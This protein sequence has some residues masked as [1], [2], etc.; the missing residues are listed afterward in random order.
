MRL[1]FSKCFFSLLFVFLCN[2]WL[3]A[4][5]TVTGGAS[6]CANNDVQFELTPPPAPAG[7]DSVAWDF[8]DPTSGKANRSNALRPQHSYFN[9]GTYTVTAKVYRNGNPVPAQNFTTD[10]T[11]KASP[12]FFDLGADTIICKKG[13][14]IDLGPYLPQPAG[15]PSYDPEPPGLIY[16]WN[17]GQTTSKITVDSAGCYSVVVTDPVTGCSIT[18]KIIVKEYRKPRQE[19]GKWFFGQNAGIDFASGSAVATSGSVNTPEGSS[20]ISDV[21]GRLQFYTDGVNVYDRTG[22]LMPNGTGLNGS[23]NSTQS[24][25]IV[26][27]PDEKSC[28]TKYLIF[29]TAPAGTAGGLQYSTVDMTLNGGK[30]DVVQKNLP[31]AGTL[32][33]TEKLTAFTSPDKKTSWVIAHDFDSRQ[34]RVIAVTKEGIEPTATKTF[35]FPASTVQGPELAKGEGQMKISSSGNRIAVTIPGAAGQPNI[36]E[37]YEFVDTSGV[38]RNPVKID[39]GTAPPPVYGVEFS[40]DGSILYVSKKGTPA[41]NIASVLYQFDAVT[42]DSINIARSKFTVDSTTAETF[43][44][45][46]IAPDQQIYM[47]MQNKSTLSVIANP[48]GNKQDAG[49]QRNAFALKSGTQS[50]LGL[51]NF[52]QNFFEPPGGQ[53]FAYRDTCTGGA[54]Q[55]F[56]FPDLAGST[57]AWDFG[58]GGTANTQQPTHNYASPGVYNAKL[59]IVN[60][61]TTETFTQQVQILRS[62]DDPQLPDQIAICT[63]QTAT[64]DP[65]PGQPGPL[66]AVYLWLTPAGLIQSRTLVATQPGKYLVQVSVANCFK[67][68]SVNITSSSPVVA[69]G[70]DKTACEGQTVQLNAGNTNLV[71]YQWFRNGQLIGGANEQF[72][73]VSTSGLYVSRVTSRITGCT[74]GDTIQVNF[75]PKARPTATTQDPTGVCGTANGSITLGNLNPGDFTF[76]WRQGSTVFAPVNP[77][78]PVNLTAGT[79]SVLIRTNGSTCDTTLF[80]ALTDPV[81]TRTRVKTIDNPATCGGD[82]S[83]TLDNTTLPS[84]PGTTTI[85]WRNALTGLVVTDIDGNDLVLLAPAGTYSVTV[86]DG[87]GCVQTLSNLILIDPARPTVKVQGGKQQT[88][89]Q[90]S[91]SLTAVASDNSTD[92]TRFSWQ[93]LQGGAAIPGSTISVNQSGDYAVIYQDNKNCLASDT[94]KVSIFAPPLITA[95]DPSPVCQGDVVNLDAGGNGDQYVWVRKGTTDTLSRSQFFTTTQAGIYVVTVGNTLAGGCQSSKEITVRVNPKPVANAGADQVVCQGSPVTL[96]TSGGAA[97][98]TYTL[99]PGGLSNQTG[100]FTIN[101][102]ATGTYTLTVTNTAGGTCSSTDQVSVQVIPKPIANLPPDAKYCAD[103]LKTVLDPDPGKQ[104]P[105]NTEYLWSTRQT[106]RTIRPRI[107]GRYWVQATIRTVVGN[108]TQV[109]TSADTITVTVEPP[110]Q[111]GK[112]PKEVNL[113]VAGGG[114]PQVMLEAGSGDNLTYRWLTSGETTQAIV[115]KDVGKYVVEISNALGCKRL[116]TIQVVP[117]CEPSVQIPTGFTPNGDGN[118]DELEVFTQFVTEFELVIY[119]RWG[120]I[121]YQTKQDGLSDKSTTS[122]WNGT[123]SGAAAPSGSYVWQIKYTSKDFTDRQQVRTRGGVMLLR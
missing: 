80:F 30:G 107:S 113:C 43:G 4:Q 88:I 23:P 44:A 77:L 39:L 86:T 76:L 55:F 117:K 63:G 67:I 114:S 38:I 95:V 96:T 101:P 48:S 102:T 57:F 110:L 60:R 83:I 103:D 14:K 78:N 58:D 56:A 15:R 29:T 105:A 26:P 74:G 20:S 19:G 27:Q 84:T 11:V 109:C 75:T 10:I 68:D 97:G 93:R 42:L 49:Y 12:K 91:I 92:N 46:Q 18:D 8:G 9:A 69:L 53:G 16:A 36:V 90:V 70:N 1:F 17:T 108:T 31:L 120:A 81:P 73:S 50:Q 40:S 2:T 21:Y 123:Y 28:G 35:S 115:V 82:G 45:L 7:L 98:A 22:V 87:G 54:T 37:L 118:N 121:V 61:C 62:P 51:P 33:N 24:A 99:Q 122:T 66:G 65:Y 5:I 52:V 106:T 104:N 112:S 100:I 13:D 47:A 71:T 85:V 89:C 25:L 79:Y 41:Q 111:A 6:Q 34:F 72:V 3:Q 94:V 116:D 59:T 32:P 64:L 119:N